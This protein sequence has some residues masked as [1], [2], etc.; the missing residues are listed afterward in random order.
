MIFF[1]YS[2]LTAW[3]CLNIHLYRGIDVY[4]LQCIIM[5][6]AMFLRLFG[7]MGLRDG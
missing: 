7:V 3:L 6:V 1:F 5:G 2:K 4:L